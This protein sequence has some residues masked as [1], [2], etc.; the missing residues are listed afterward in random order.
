MIAI[1]FHLMAPRLTCKHLRE[2]KLTECVAVSQRYSDS[3]EIRV[4][5]AILASKDNSVQ[6]R[7]EQAKKLVYAS[8]GRYLGV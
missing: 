4:Q 3:L 1:Y 6:P 2:V 5:D 8:S 7:E